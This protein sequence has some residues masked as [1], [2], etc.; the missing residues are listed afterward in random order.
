LSTCDVDR[1]EDLARLGELGQHVLEVVALAEAEALGQ[2]DDQVALGGARRADQQQRLLG[3]RAQDR[4]VDLL[5]AGDEVL[6]EAAAVLQHARAD[7]VDLGLKL[8]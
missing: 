8:L 3:D 4:Q 5:V 7:V 2:L 1:A 6:L